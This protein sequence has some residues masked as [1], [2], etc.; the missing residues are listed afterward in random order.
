M[1]TYPASEHCPCCGRDW[2]YRDYATLPG[3]GNAHGLTVTR[4]W[5]HGYARFQ[6]VTTSITATTWLHEIEEVAFEAVRD[7]AYRQWN[8]PLAEQEQAAREC[9][10]ASR[11]YQSQIEYAC[12]I[13]D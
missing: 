11:R 1:K 9:D 5:E 3:F 8:R 2:C 7:E 10:A 4:T 6:A 12:G 13:W